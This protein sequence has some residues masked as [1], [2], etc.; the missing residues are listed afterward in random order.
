MLNFVADTNI[1]SSGLL[2][3]GNESKLLKKAEQGKIR[4]FT[5]K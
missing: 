3:K 4:L 5:T 1:V 2:W